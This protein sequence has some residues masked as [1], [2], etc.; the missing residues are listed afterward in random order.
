MRQAA[1]SSSGRTALI[2][3]AMSLVAGCTFQAPSPS[4]EGTQLPELPVV[5][6]PAAAAG[7][8]PWIQG[9]GVFRGEFTIGETYGTLNDFEVAVATR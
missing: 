3:V 2:A 1:P 8:T 7:A 5:P 6:I 9:V 4:A